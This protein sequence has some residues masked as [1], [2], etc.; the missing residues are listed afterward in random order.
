MI[1]DDIRENTPGRT[2]QRAFTLVEL[3]AVSRRKSR[4]FTLVE[5]LIVIV[6]IGLLVTILMPTVGRVR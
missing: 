1:A 6:I 2:R 4:A 3:P 5:L